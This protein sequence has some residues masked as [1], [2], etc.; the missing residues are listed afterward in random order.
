MERRC[1]NSSVRRETTPAGNLLAA[2]NESLGGKVASSSSRTGRCLRL[3][4]RETTISSAADHSG[5]GGSCVFAL[6]QEPPEIELAPSARKL[7]TASSS[8]LASMAGQRK[9]SS[10][11]AL[12]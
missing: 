6:E 11:A 8:P 1:S 3:E 4:G 5:H 2:G 7:R 10:S 9:K 12:E